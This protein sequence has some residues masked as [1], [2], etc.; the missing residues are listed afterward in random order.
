MRVYIMI[1]NFFV[2]GAQKYAVFLAN[3]YSEKG[4]TVTV[5]TSNIDGPFK[6]LLLPNIEVKVFRVPV[7]KSLK[8][9]VSFSKALNKLIEPGSL[10]ICNGPNNFRQI[11]R[12]N[13]FFRRWKILQVLHNDNNIQKSTFSFLKTF[14][15]RVLFNQKHVR[16]I[17]LTHKQKIDHENRLGLRNVSVIPNFI[18]LK[19]F[20]LTTLSKKNPIGVSLGRYAPEKGY[21]VLLSAMKQ[22][23]KGIRLDVYGAGEKERL[24]LVKEAEQENVSN[25]RFN[26]PVLNVP[27]TLYKYDFYVLPSQSE[28]FG[29]VLIE[30]NACGLPIIA[31]DCDGPMEIVDNES[32]L[33]VPKNNATDLAKGITQLH[34]LVQEGYYDPKV[35]RQKSLKYGTE[36]VIE[37]YLG[38]FD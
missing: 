27:E 37:L 32:G 13:L 8:R 36:N 11:A 15:V 14:E 16:V 18:E 4:Y 21:D 17:A 3:A 30:A 23:S 26:G 10:I 2:G 31:T 38:V 5:L 28:S 22:V 29:L 7:V 20:T 35:I 9:L 33:I 12:L 24:R 1:W 34:K 6:D 19:D 25:I